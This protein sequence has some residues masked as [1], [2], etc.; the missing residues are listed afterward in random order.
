[1]IAF[2]RRLAA[3]LAS[4]LALSAAASTTFSTD[5]T[6]LWITPNESGHGMYIV[7]QGNT[8]FVTLFVYGGDTLPRWYFASSVTPVNGSTTRWRGEPYPSQ[9]PPLPPPRDPGGLVVFTSRSLR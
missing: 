2:L 9:G 5:Y 7:Q 3:V 4:S 6:D 1:M 8:M